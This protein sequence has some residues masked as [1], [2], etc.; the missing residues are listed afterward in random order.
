MADSLHEHHGSVV[1]DGGDDAIMPTRKRQSPLDAPFG[2]H[3]EQQ[4]PRSDARRAL[5]RRS[6]AFAGFLY[7]IWEAAP[8]ETA[9]CRS[10]EGN[11]WGEDQQLATF[12]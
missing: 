7:G 11:Q 4:L 6:I 5:S 2:V 12:V 3:A 8:E 1:L 9:E 10:N